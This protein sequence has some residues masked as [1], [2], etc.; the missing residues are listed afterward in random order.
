MKTDMIQA[1]RYK[2]IIFDVGDTLLTREPSSHN[3][4]IEKCQEI[5]LT[6]DESTARSAFKQAEIWA[7]NQALCEMNG[8]PRMPDREFDQH[9][10]MTV[11]RT[12]FK[13]KAEDELVQL[14]DQLKAMPSPKQAWVLVS[15]VHQTLKKLKESGVILG[16]A[17]NFDE[18]L[19]D[20]CDQLG[21]TP[22][23]DTIVVSSLVGIEKPNP[24][25]MRIACHRLDIAPST[26]L[27]VGDHPLDVFCAKEAGMSV[28]WLCDPE[29][30]LPEQ[31]RYQADYRIHS[32]GEIT[33]RLGM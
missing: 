21:L 10:F 31:I 30:V 1:D 2:A 5:G 33:V 29:D 16:I 19:P 12:A 23:F 7:G 22:Y 26:S 13:E 32:P 9:F 20:L 18:T 3:L 8:E 28:A 6:L 27:Y 17:S 25:I 14:R 11:L 24:E 4:L 15:G